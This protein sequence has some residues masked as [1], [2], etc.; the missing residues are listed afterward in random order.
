M[1]GEFKDCLRVYFSGTIQTTSDWKLGM[2]FTHWYA[3]NVGAIKG[4]VSMAYRHPVEK[5]VTMIYSFKLISATI[6]GVHYGFPE[7]LGGS[8]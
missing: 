2:D 1:G 7:I 4:N 3:P 6:D 8:Q 5:A